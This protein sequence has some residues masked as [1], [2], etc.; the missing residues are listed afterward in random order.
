MVMIQIELADED[1]RWL[2]D[3]RGHGVRGHRRLGRAGRPR[4][5]RPALDRLC[6]LR[7]EL[8]LVYE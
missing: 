4:K 3:R 6:R 7:V 8:C 5:P 2:R 1:G